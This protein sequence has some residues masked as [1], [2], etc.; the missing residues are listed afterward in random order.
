[1]GQGVQLYQSPYPSVIPA[2]AS[3]E[4][5]LLC[6]ITMTSAQSLINKLLTCCRLPG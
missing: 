5:T 3:G 6:M 2:D 1:M 4:L